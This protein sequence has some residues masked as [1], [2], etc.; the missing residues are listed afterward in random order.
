MSVATSALTQGWAVD[1]VAGAGAA[2]LRFVAPRGNKKIK[3]DYASHTAGAASH[4][5]TFMFP[6]AKTTLNVA[7]AAA[8]TSVQL[9]R[10]PGNYSGN[11][12]TDGT[13]TP[14][15]SNNN[16]SAGNGTF[17]AFQ[18]PDGNWFQTTASANGTLNAN[19]TVTLPITDAVPTGGLAAGA[20]V[21]YYGAPTSTNPNTGQAHDQYNIAVN[22]TLNMT[23]S[24]V[25]VSPRMGDSL[26]IHVNNGA[27]NNGTF[28]KAGGHYG[29]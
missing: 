26:L 9:V 5:L 14:S 18:Q 13:A 22:S 20:M 10:D 25:A 3:V 16:I 29:P 19:G 28:E 24:P 23:D 21:H 17:I 8:A 4:T 27:S 12:I 1:R 7:A 15:V 2:I 6:L 11:A